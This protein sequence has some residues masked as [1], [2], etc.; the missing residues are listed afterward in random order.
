LSSASIKLKILGFI[1]PYIEN[2]V[3]HGLRYKEEHGKLN[4]NFEQKNDYVEI[5]IS[6]D[7]IGRKKSKEI[8]TENQKIMKSTGLKNIENRLQIIKEVY[9]VQL[10]VT[11][12]DLD[13]RSNAGI[14]VV[15]KLPRNTFVNDLKAANKFQKATN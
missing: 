11:I 15:I 6:D 12:T 3:W 2:A 13:N 10:D 4:V 7:G 1:Q 9:S 8:K 5:S 14:K